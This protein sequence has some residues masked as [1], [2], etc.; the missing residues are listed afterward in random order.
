[1]SEYRILEPVTYAHD[2]IVTQHKKAGAFVEL[3]D[4]VAAELGDAVQL[5]VRPDVEPEKAAEPVADGQP[6]TVL[7]TVTEV[8]QVVGGTPEGDVT[9]AVVTPED[10]SEAKADP[11]AAGE[12]PKPRRGRSG[13]GDG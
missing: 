13:G 3:S 6:A 4:D 11:E 1:M 9:T 7:D 12:S 8:T 2:G 5:I 10:D